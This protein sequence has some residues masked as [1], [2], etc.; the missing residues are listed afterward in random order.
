MKIVDVNINCLDQLNAFYSYIELYIGNIHIF[1]FGFPLPHTFNCSPLNVSNYRMDWSSSKHIH[2]IVIYSHV[3]TF[4]G[5]IYNF[6]YITFFIL[7][8]LIVSH[9]HHKILITTIFFCVCCFL[10]TQHCDA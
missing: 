9:I 8:F 2:I 3:F 7:F 5:A 4:I 1:L 6:S 10:I